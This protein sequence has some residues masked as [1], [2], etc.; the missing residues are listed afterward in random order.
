MQ[1]STTSTA[2]ATR[3]LPIHG[4]LVI[5]ILLSDDIPAYRPYS[6]HAPAGSTITAGSCRD[7]F[8]VLSRII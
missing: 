1:Q 5:S 3:D 2:V 4:H 8:T 7:R 6:H